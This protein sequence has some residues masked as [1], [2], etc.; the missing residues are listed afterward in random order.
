MHFMAI[1]LPQLLPYV[2][3][4]YGQTTE[5]WFGDRVVENTRGSQQG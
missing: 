4:A 5:L 2:T 3:A 1:H